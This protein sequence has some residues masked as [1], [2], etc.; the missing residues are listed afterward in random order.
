MYIGYKF[1][2]NYLKD[3][4]NTDLN[5]RIHYVSQSVNSNSISDPSYS[6]VTPY[7]FGITSIPTNEVFPLSVPFYQGTELQS[8]ITNIFYT[9]THTGQL[10]EQVLASG[11]NKGS[12]TSV[13]SDKHKPSIIPVNQL[14]IGN[15]RRQSAFLGDIFC[16][17]YYK[18]KQLV[19]EMMGEPMGY[20]RKIVINFSDVSKLEFQSSVEKCSVMIVELTKLPAFYTEV[21]PQPG[22]NV[23]WNVCQ[24]F[25][26]G[27]ASIY[28]KHILYFSKNALTK[29]LNKLMLDEHLKRV[30]TVPNILGLLS[31]DATNQ[32]D[33]KEDDEE[34]D[35]D[36]DE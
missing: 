31:K 1:L 5:P 3:M 35:E 2:L 6:F 36:S 28:N 9:T 11:S 22:K 21:N 30:I 10:S 15:W 33:W 34:E 12:T 25:T 13:S 32:Q 4:D 16:K 23:Q 26:A 20:L 19:W 8:P 14:Q 7:R 18:K 27:Q 29:H 24:D 17:F